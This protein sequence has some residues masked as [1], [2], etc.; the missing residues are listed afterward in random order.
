MIC[1]VSNF[2]VNSLTKTELISVFG[3]QNKGYEQNC[4]N[5]GGT[6]AAL[7]DLKERTSFMSWL[8]CDDQ[9]YN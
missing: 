9:K 8:K 6:V 7:F 2:L 3:G 1:Q 5:N 4:K